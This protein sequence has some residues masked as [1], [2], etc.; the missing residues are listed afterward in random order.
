[1]T[2]TE[3]LEARIGER[4]AVARAVGGLPWKWVKTREPG[5]DE[6]RWSLM[7]EDGSVAVHTQDA[8]NYASW[9]T[10]KQQ[11][12]DTE[13]VEQFY[14]WTEA[15]D[16]ARVLAECASI[17]AILARCVPLDDIQVRRQTRMLA[18]D[19]L[20]ALTLPYLDHPD[21]DEAWRP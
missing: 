13:N 18:H 7:R 20:C 17:R 16:P 6:D 9:L 14:A 15:I 3:F 10:T 11:H 4:E 5:L 19:V 1:M 21:F 8:E 2:L 12:D